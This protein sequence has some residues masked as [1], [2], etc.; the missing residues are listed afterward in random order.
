MAVTVAQVAVDARY[1]VLSLLCCV[2]AIAYIQRAAMGVPAGEIAHGLGSSDLARDMGYVQ[3]A[4]YAGYA[5]LQLPSGWLADRLGSRITV[6]ILAALWSL[7]TMVAAG[8][9]SIFVLAS[10]WGLMGA[11]QA[12]V[13][14]CATK[15]IGATFPQG[16]RA[17]ASGMLAA[18]MTIGAAVAPMITSLALEA[19]MPASQAT[20]VERWRLLLVAYALPGFAWVL[21][22]WFMV[23]NALLPVSPLGS[24][25]DPVD[26]SRMFRSIDLLLLCAQQFFRAAAMVFFVT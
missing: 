22:F 1:R 18:G 25:P 2:A 16:E 17:R 15:A 23:P 8:S 19:L 21:L 5:L 3:S 24:A 12:G 10:V 11:A 7:L 13:F 20:G 4:W 14:P 6:L 9:T 26:W